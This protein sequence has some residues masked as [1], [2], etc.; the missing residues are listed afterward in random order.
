MRTELG[1][2]DQL[3]ILFAVFLVL[4]FF[5]AI[6][7]QDAAGNITLFEAY[8]EMVSSLTTTGASVFADPTDISLSL[9]LWR[10]E[11]AWLGGY[12]MLVAAASIL[13][14]MHLGGYEV[15]GAMAA[16]CADLSRT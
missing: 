3:L 13:A 9:H 5:M 14:P 1:Q 11:V 10:A 8:F 4:P 16:D 12:I 6:P 2:R 7:L 15:I